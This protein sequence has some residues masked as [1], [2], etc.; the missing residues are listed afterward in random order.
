[1]TLHVGFVVALTL[2][3]AAWADD[4]ENRAKLIGN[5]QAQNGE[6][7]PEVWSLERN[8]ESLRVTESRGDQTILEY[9][10]N[11]QGK[12][13]LIK[14]SG[15]PAKLSMWFNGSILVLVIGISI[16]TLPLSM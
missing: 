15:K 3:C 6:A 13:C 10:C 8:G 4:G 16:R 5:W 14:V 2:S 12:E 7:S 11:T 9:E 1:M